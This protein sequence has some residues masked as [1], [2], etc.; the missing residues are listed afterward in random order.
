MSQERRGRLANERIAG[1]GEKTIGQ[2]GNTGEPRGNDSRRV[3]ANEKGVSNEARWHPP[4]VIGH[5]G[6]DKGWMNSR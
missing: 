2:L 1:G 3:E 5:V 4:V 6:N